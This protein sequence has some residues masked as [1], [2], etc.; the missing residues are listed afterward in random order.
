M[1]KVGFS[2]WPP[3][4]QKIGQ[5]AKKKKKSLGV[6]P[7]GILT[8]SFVEIALVVTKRALPTDATSLL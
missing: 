2:R 3:G 4:G 1:A 6:L 8:P 5:I 7:K